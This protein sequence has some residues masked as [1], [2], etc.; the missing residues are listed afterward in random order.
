MLAMLITEGTKY[1]CH[2]GFVRDRITVILVIIRGLSEIQNLNI[3]NCRPRLRPNFRLVY[4]LIFISS[5][6]D[7][8]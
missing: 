8:I 3:Q 1:A 2:I 7:H 4:S 5:V 6:R